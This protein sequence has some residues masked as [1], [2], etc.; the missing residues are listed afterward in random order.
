M[1]IPTAIRARAA[2][3]IF[4]SLEV[5][6]FARDLSWCLVIFR[7][8]QMVSIYSL[9]GSVHSGAVFSPIIRGGPSVRVAG[10]ILPVGT[11]LFLRI[12]SRDVQHH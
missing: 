3:V 4:S 1:I 5:A 12:P 10:I 2:L 11:S 6:C 7:P 8:F 9:L